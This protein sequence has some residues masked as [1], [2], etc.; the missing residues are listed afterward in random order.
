MSTVRLT[1][2]DGVL[3]NL[4]PAIEPGL[5]LLV[6]G[7]PMVLDASRRNQLRAAGNGCVPLAASLAFVIL[8]G[9]AGLI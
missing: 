2:L 5:C 7:T 1:Q 3:P 9:E 8:A 4:A 6:D